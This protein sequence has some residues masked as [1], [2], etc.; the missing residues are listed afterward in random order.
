ME[1]ARPPRRR[2]RPRRGTVDRPL[3]TRLVRVGLV[4]VA[5]ALLALLFSVSTAGTLSRP[6]VDPSFDAAA[7]AATAATLSTEYPSRVPGT[8]EAIQAA[9]WYRETVASLGLPAEV[10]A[11]N[12]E[13]PDLGVVE[14]R[15]VVSVIRGRSD[16]AILLVAHRDNA[17][18]P[19]VRRDNA[20][21]TA[22][23]IEIARGFGSRTGSP[24]PL[25]E[26]TLVLLSADAGAYG[27]AGTARFARESPIA[28]SVIAAVVV[29]DIGRQGRPR[30]LLAGNGSSSPSRTL[31][32][33]ASARIAEQTGE[34]LA[35]P[36]LATQLVDLGVPFAG[37]EQGPLLGEGIPG[38][39]IT[40][41]QKRS[42][43]VPSVG[44]SALAVQ[45]Y[46]QVGTAVEALLGSLDASV[47]TR[48]R[49][50]DSLFFGDRVASGWALRLTLVV[51]IVPFALGVLDL[52]VRSRR[53]RLGFGSAARSLRDRLLFWL[54]C[55]VLLAIGAGI[56]ALPT[57]PALALPAESSY[58]SDPAI[59]RLAL[60]GAAAILGWLAWR[61][62]LASGASPRS[63]ERVAGYSVALS[64]LG[65][66]AIAAAVFKPY[67]LLF[68]LPSLYAWL[69]LP[70][71]T[72]AWA[73]WSLFV[74][75]LAGPLVGILVLGHELA[76]G[77]ADTLLYLAGLV[78]AGYVSLPTLLLGLAWA[79]SAAQLAVLAFGRYTQYG[80]AETGRSERREQ[81]Y[82]SAR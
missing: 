75:G 71:R 79:A 33:T 30:L 63:E 53:K 17:G 25:S 36:S 5:P 52:L 19:T 8:A 40:T 38:V 67:A 28:E 54:Y 72:A 68:V 82:S 26:R 7:A 31:V 51:S 45:R 48:F 60:L 2:R 9:H 46:G 55:G 22:A 6:P 47:R 65:L 58:V 32:A 49:T 62:H 35:L 74:L 37:G 13:L 69:W 81:S 57:A 42:P 29:D 56:G 16:E 76:L 66:V 11:W 50:P 70:I 1:A 34:R 39:T 3:D 12:E 80:S 4:V 73:R 14:L 61:R 43:D 15:N 44:P 64:W 77:P 41:A 78:T 20:S 27:G 10:V 18:Q 23:L 59:G 21:G 24:A